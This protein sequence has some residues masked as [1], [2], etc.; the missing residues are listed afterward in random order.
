MEE[1]EHGVMETVNYTYEDLL[2]ID[3]YENRELYLDGEINQESIQPIIFHIIRYNRMDKDVPVDMRLPIILYINSPGGDV[4]AGYSVIDI[5]SNSK[6]PVYTVNIGMCDSMALYIFIAGKKRYSMPH[7][8]FLLH[9]GCTGYM[10]STA[11]VKDRVDF[12]MKQLEQMNKDYILAHT[13]ISSKEY[14]SKY[15]MEYYF[16]PKEAK[17]IGVLDYIIGEDC[18]MSEELYIDHQYCEVSENEENPEV[19]EVDEGV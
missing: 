15:R 13:S 11:K 1:R 17:E 14:N 16:L 3:S 8:E 9:D 18:D 6:T 12:E 19:N 7:S 2:L 10:N 5:I 4:T